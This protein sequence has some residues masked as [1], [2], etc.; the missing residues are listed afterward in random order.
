MRAQTASRLD[1]RDTI[2]VQ[3]VHQICDELRTL[4]DVFHVQRFQQPDGHGLHGTDFHTAVGE[5]AFIEGDESHH[6]VDVLLVVGSNDPAAGEAQL[7]A[8]EVDDVHL[9]GE[10]MIDLPSG[11]V[12]ALSLA[13]FHEV[14][15]VLQERSIEHALDAV[16]MTDVGDGKHVFEGN[17]LSADQVRAGFDADESNLLGAVGFDGLLQGPQ[18]EI[19]FEGVFALG[20]ESFL[21]HKFNH[22][23][24][25]TG[26]V[27]LGRGKVEI[28]QSDHTR[29]DIGFSENILSSP[30]LVSRKDV[31]RTKNL[32]DSRLDAVESFA[33]G[34]GVIRDA[35]GGHLFIRHR[36][37]AGVGDHVHVDILVLQ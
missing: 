15:V 16:V 19:A 30:T 33:A 21:V 13:H 18:V 3:L 23:T 20:N 14:N 17:R 1:H 22:L 29:L 5:E 37:D 7:A 6:L 8:R 36:V 9:V 4:A 35:H 31:I 27:G 32:L 12:L 25:Q 11:H 34:I 28:H 10:N 26:D 24:A 2:L